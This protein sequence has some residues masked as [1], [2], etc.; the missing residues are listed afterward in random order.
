MVARSGTPDFDARHVERFTGFDD[1]RRLARAQEVNMSEAGHAQRAVGVDQRGR[2]LING[3]AASFRE[4]VI[5]Q[6]TR[7][8]RQRAAHAITLVKVAVGDGVAEQWNVEKV[9]T[10]SYVFIEG[11]GQALARC[12]GV[13]GGRKNVFA[14]YR[15][16]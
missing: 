5:M 3:N 13:F 12:D 1:A 10:D 6:H 15:E 11:I 2:A 16:S 8:E 14:Q 7:K 9:G 4:F